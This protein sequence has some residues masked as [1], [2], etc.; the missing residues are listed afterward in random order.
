MP[1]PVLGE[2][3]DHWEATTL[4]EICDRGGGNIQTGPFGSQLHAS[5]YVPVGI[6]SIMPVNIGKNR[7]V[8][9]D[10]KRIT[11]EDAERLSKHRVVPGDIIYSRR[12]DVERRALVREEQRG[13]LCG[14][15][16]MKVRLGSG[17][18]N[19]KFASF[20]LDHPQVREWIVQHAVGATM[21]NLNTGIMR[22]IPFA[23]PPMNEQ[24]A[25]A[26]IL[27]TLDA[28]IELN[29]RMNETLESMARAIFKSWFVDFDPVR[30]KMD[31][32]QPTG[33][34]ADTASLFPDSF[35]DVDGL[36]VP[37]GWRK[38]TVSDISEGLYD[39]PHATPEKSDAGP[40]F[41]GIKNLTGTKVDLSEIRHISEEDWP[42]WTK[43]I[44]PKHGDIVFTYEATLGYFAIIPPNLRCCLG[45]RLA[46]IRPKP[47]TRLRHFV[48][49]SFTSDP[50]L[51]Y[52][53]AHA[54]HGATVNRVPLSEFPN[55]PLLWPSKELVS[56]FEDLTE[57]IWNRIHAN[58]RLSAILAS[59]RDMLL[60]KLLSGELRVGDAM[61]Q[62]D[63]AMLSPAGEPAGAEA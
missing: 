31:G 18:A 27:G 29:R 8:E 49:H 40:V 42:R 44:E 25:I 50:F 47:E 21:P 20:Y 7:L 35:E 11:E 24:K 57:P 55:Y 34:D 46:L 30:A 32:R 14:T 17:V 37:S 33:M 59:L 4:G 39:G 48:F 13:W 52:L 23:L 3:P 41:L 5:D 53:D 45:R 51:V 15:G 36:L 43:R 22:A 10:I 38:I 12:G 56:R 16:C 60:P 9:D 1:N 58:D 6:P 2:F 62:V 26:H 61:K 19:P 63:D 28:K 54:I